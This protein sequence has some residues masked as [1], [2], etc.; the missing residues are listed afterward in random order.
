MTA[1]LSHLMV[2]DI[3]TGPIN[4]IYP[5]GDLI[6]NSPIKGG[7]L[8]DI[9]LETVLFILMAIIVMTRYYSFKRNEDI[10]LFRY[11]CKMDTFLYS[12]LILAIIISVFYVL[13]EFKFTLVE[14]SIAIL[15]HSAAISIIM[16]IWLASKCTKR[17]EH[18]ISDP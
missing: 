12:V 10:F 17:Q 14:V 8:Q 6:V 2:G 11:H 3:L 7:S 5:L 4:I 18:V 9:L 15:L 1:Y 13:A 16:L